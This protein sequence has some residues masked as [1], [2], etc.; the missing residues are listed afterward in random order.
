MGMRDLVVSGVGLAACLLLA[1]ASSG[2]YA[3]VELQQVPVE[4][5]VTK[6]EGIVKKNPKNVQALINLARVH[7]MAYALKTDKVP[8]QKGHEERG[9]W[10][11]HEPKFVPFSK[12][13][14][15]GDTDKQKVAKAQLAK[16]IERFKEAV[17]LAPDNVMA[18]LG[19][20]WT[21]DQSGEKKEAIKEY[22]ALIDDAW[23]KEKDL[24]GLD[25]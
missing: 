13:E 25:L 8:V 21:L 22:R 12:V 3:A 10:F 15:S 1:A 19:Y 18:R 2:K 4:R 11:G 24:K 9:S 17:K 7:G 6:L 23:K 20:A 14:E 5:L 16:A